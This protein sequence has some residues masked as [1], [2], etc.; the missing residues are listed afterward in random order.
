[1]SAKCSLAYLMFNMRRVIK[2][3]TILVRNSLVSQVLV[4]ILR[5]L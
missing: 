1:M 5:G 3:N 2:K 4:R